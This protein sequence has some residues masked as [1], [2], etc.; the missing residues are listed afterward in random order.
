MSLE[1]ELKANTAA[2]K[3]LTETMTALAKSGGAPAGGGTG[4]T[5]AKKVSVDDLKARAGEY[6]NSVEDRAERDKLKEPLKRCLK[7][8]NIEKFPDLPEEHR[9]EMMDKFDIL[10]A[11]FNEGGVEAA[12]AADIGLPDGDNDDDII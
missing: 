7:H 2:I 6:L 5:K 9:A 10:I 3:K 1:S 12:V 11:A 4:G 8:Y